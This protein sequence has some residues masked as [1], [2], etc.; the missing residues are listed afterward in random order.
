[1]ISNFFC[2]KGHFTPVPTS[3]SSFHRLHG[4]SLLSL[5]ILQLHVSPFRLYLS[6]KLFVYVSLTEVP[7]I[8]WRRSARS[9]PRHRMGVDGHLHSSAALS[10][11]S[12]C[13]CVGSK[14]ETDEMRS[15][16]S[17]LVG[18]ELRFLDRPVIRGWWHPFV[19]AVLYCLLKARYKENVS[20]YRPGQA[21]RAPR[22]WGFQDCRQQ[23]KVVRLTALRT[24]RLYSQ[25]STSGTHFR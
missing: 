5:Y 15:D 21:L 7:Q 17:D 20:H 12:V 25:G 11:H 9:Y 19:L 1:M 23:M 6:A 24:G 13:W 22:G 16:I 18:D 14:G 8:K 2:R 4:L 3:E 10:P